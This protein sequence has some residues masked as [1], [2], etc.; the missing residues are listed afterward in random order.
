M[1]RFQQININLPSSFSK[2]EKEI[3]FRTTPQPSFNKQ[4]E[5]LISYLNDKHTEGYQNY[6]LCGSEQQAKRFH[7]IFEE[8]EQKVQR[9]A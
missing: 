7:D 6:I 5:L 2:G 4:F 3:V 9:Y 1:G 8:M